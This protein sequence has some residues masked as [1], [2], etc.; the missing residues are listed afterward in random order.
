[1]K[2]LGK[3]A[4]LRDIPQIGIG[5]N[6]LT[7]SVSKDRLLTTGDPLWWAGFENPRLKKY[8]DCIPKRGILRLLFP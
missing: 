6:T 3:Q 7:K 1:M 8:F 5:L 2:V 4:K